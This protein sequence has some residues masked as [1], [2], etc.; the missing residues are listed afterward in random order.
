MRFIVALLVLIVAGPAFAQGSITYSWTLP[1]SGV[2][3]T[4]TVPVAASDL[5]SSTVEYG[6]CN[7]AAF[8][9]KAGQIVVASPGTTGVV[10]GLAPGDYCG[11]VFVTMTAA[12]GGTSS[13]VSNVAKR[14]IVPPPIKPNPPTLLDAIVAFLRR[15]FGHFA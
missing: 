15:L 1:T 12:K 4:A 13:D 14:T 2:Q 3:G 11:R 6:T 7:G 10:N 8:G 5:A 9:T